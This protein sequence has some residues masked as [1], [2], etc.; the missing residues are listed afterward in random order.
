MAN[1]T[2]HFKTTKHLLDGGSVK[3]EHRPYLGMSGLG[4]ECSRY[5]WYSFRWAFS[6][7]TTPRMIRLWARGHR[8]EPAIIAELEK[9]GITCDDDQGEVIAGF[10][11]IKGHKDGSAIGVIEAPKT[12]HLLEFKTVNDK[13]F[14]KLVTEKVKKY[15]PVY[16]AQVQ[17]YMHFFDLTRTLFIAVNK[18]DDSYHVERIKY[19]KGFA[20]D[21]VRKGESIVIAGS[22]PSRAF[23]NKSFFKCRWC[24]ASNTCWSGADMDKNCRTC[25]YV[26]PMVEGE[27][28][29]TFFGVEDVVP[30]IPLDVQR[31]GCS[32]YVQLQQEV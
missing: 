20:E 31:K 32:N 29:C 6:D 17:L 26:V 4:H 7:S 5:I 28:G 11:H 12:R 13:G 25:E 24:A 15:S 23:P 3:L 16:Y 27:W 22:P 19:D 8:E 1:L 10:G 21:L 30:P 9:I 2:Q 18:N 14:K